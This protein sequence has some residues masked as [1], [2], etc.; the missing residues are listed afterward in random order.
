MQLLLLNYWDSSIP[1]S[2]K[3]QLFNPGARFQPLREKSASTK[4]P[5]ANKEGPHKRRIWITVAELAW[6]EHFHSNLV[7]EAR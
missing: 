3:V 6:T 5:I 4:P 2:D 1:T 7:Q